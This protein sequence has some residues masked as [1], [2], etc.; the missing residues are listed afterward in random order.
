MAMTDVASLLQHWR[1][2]PPAHVTLHALRLD[3]LA[4]HGI[5][6]AGSRQATGN[7]AAMLVDEQAVR[8]LVA[9]ANGG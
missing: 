4:A 5:E 8:S 2:C 6:A 1:R 7:G 3:Y 9:T